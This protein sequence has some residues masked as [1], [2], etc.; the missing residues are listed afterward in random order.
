MTNSDELVKRLDDWARDT[1]V[2]AVV[3]NLAAKCASCIRD[4]R[5]EIE[6]LDFLRHEGGEDSVAAMESKL[7]GVHAGS[8][9][10]VPVEPT[11]AMLKSAWDA[12][13]AQDLWD[14]QQRDIYAA[15]IKSAQ[16]QPK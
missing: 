4:L 13:D 9:V 10:I 3:R 11:E 15:M 16:E 6:E 1:C 2:D 14:K 8:H 12:F 5:C 7:A